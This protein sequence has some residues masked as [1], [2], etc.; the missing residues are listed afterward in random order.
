MLFNL[1]NT[2]YNTYFKSVFKQNE[3]TWKYINS[4][5]HKKNFSKIYYLNSDDFFFDN[6]DCFSNVF[7]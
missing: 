6:Q 4:K 3:N 7:M 2:T 5:T 1:I